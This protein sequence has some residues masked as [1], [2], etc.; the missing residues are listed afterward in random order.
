[1]SSNEGYN[2]K[3]NLEKLTEAEQEYEE[4]LPLEQHIVHFS[5]RYNEE[6]QFR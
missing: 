6:K 3:E 4:V 2:R 5:E 1:M